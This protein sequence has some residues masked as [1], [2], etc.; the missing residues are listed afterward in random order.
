MKIFDILIEGNIE[1]IRGEIPPSMF[2]KDKV[3][4]GASA[5]VYRADSPNRVIKVLNIE[6]EADG[7]YRYIDMIMDHQYNRYFPRVYNA[8]LYSFD[9]PNDRESRLFIE[10]EKL[11]PFR[12]MQSEHLLP[13]LIKEFGI[14]PK[15]AM[16]H[17][18]DE[19]VADLENN[20]ARNAGGEMMARQ[21]KYMFG[22]AE[23]RRYLMANIKNQDLKEAIALTA[24]ILD[25]NKHDN[26][27]KADEG[28]LHADNIMIRL[29]NNMPQLVIADPIM[30]YWT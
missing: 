5:N 29:T 25:N 22:D 20:P 19:E 18:S 6:N 10:M 9:F 12:K 1:H 14:D 11:V 17:F 23:G 24:Q 7:T 27:G 13:L 8:K 3:G 15:D 21:L 30:T 4:K 28:D 16:D 2:G 26:D